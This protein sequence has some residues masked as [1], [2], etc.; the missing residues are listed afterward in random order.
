MTSET[1]SNSD[2]TPPPQQNGGEP[3]APQTIHHWPNM[4]AAVRDK[5]QIDS[6]DFNSDI[7][8][9]QT[10]YGILLVLG[11]RQIGDTLYNMFVA[12]E[13]HNL[14]LCASVAL[15]AIA[16][17]FLGTRFF[18]AVGNIRR[19]YLR[20]ERY[21]PNRNARRV[22]TTVHFPILLLHAF[23]FYVLCRFH[24]EMTSTKAIEN[25]WDWFVLW[26]ASFLL[27][28]VMWLYQLVRRPVGRSVRAEPVSQ[29]N[30]FG[31]L[32]VGW[33]KNRQWI[34][35]RQPESTWI[36]LNELTALLVLAIVWFGNLVVN[37]STALLVTACIVLILNSLLN[38]WL[39]ADTYVAKIP[40]EA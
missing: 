24:S 25:G 14:E 17:A 19:Y 9:M 40:K 26:F 28:N 30:S 7:G 6:R 37:D 2:A 10:V 34:K 36:I 3:I 4:K 32:E 33:S 21:E 11:F 22:I 39:T 31:W 35:D 29:T 13:A 16:L 15:S 20:N 5:E 1:K 8:L 12:K 18:W 27:L 38:L 23:V